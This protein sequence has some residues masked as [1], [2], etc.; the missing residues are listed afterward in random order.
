MD[1]KENK[2]TKEKH[3]CLQAC[4][5]AMQN[6]ERSCIAMNINTDRIMGMMRLIVRSNLCFMLAY[7]IKYSLL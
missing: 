2:Q 1:L 4:I 3:L 5:F 6:Q 7:P